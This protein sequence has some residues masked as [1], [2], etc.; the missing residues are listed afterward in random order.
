VRQTISGS[1][2]GP[3]CEPRK[4]IK[5]GKGSGT[6]LRIAIHDEMLLPLSSV[7]CA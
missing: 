4:W 2:D 1:S 5:T 7:R 6:C 3:G